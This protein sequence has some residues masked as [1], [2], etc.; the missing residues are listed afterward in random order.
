MKDSVKKYLEGSPPQLQP[1]GFLHKRGRHKMANL[2]HSERLLRIQAAR[3]KKQNE[4]MSKVSD[5]LA[6][7]EVKN[8]QL[9]KAIEDSKTDKG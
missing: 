8:T 2:T 1:E 5:Q 7:S 6:V 4:E 3:M 9:E